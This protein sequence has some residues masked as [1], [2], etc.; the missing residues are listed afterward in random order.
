MFVIVVAASIVGVAGAT[1]GACAGAFLL[2][3]MFARRLKHDRWWDNHEL[4]S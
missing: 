1:A 4:G 3:S 2:G